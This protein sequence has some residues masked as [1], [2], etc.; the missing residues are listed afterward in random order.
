MISEIVNFVSAK[1]IAEMVVS[2]CGTYM[3]KVNLMSDEEFKNIFFCLHG[4]KEVV[5]ECSNELK[6]I[7]RNLPS[8]YLQPRLKDIKKYLDSIE[9]KYI[10]NFKG[11]TIV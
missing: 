8:D 7:L 4:R 2:K 9:I 5:I 6:E 11:T 10:E 1:P 3:E